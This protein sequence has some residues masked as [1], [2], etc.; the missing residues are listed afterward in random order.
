MLQN[1]KEEVECDLPK[2][3]GT[4]LMPK[5]LP[6]SSSTR[7]LKKKL[8]QISRSKRKA[9]KLKR[10]LKGEKDLLDLPILKLLMRGNA[11]RMRTS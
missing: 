2:D 11:L 1:L 7:R 8:G 6:G 9:G 3:K 5:R 10:E 4:P